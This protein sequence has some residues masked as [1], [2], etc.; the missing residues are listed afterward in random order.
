VLRIVGLK[1]TYGRVSNRGVI[2]LSWTLDHAARWCKTVDDAAVL[3]AV[4][5]GLIRWI[6]RAS[7]C[8]CPITRVPSERD[9]RK[10]EW[11]FRVPA[12]STTCTRKS[13]WP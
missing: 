8:R 3:L 12:S 2:P 9:P 6:R 10:C 7:I 1:P 5:S 4:T 13:P 11:A